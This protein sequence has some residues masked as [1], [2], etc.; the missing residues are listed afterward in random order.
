[1]KQENCEIVILFSQVVCLSDNGNELNFIFFSSLYCFVE[2][3]VLPV[4]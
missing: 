3:L 2:S 4:V 1:M